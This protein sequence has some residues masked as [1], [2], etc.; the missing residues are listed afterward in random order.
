MAKEE[1]VKE[2]EIAPIE[3]DDRL[4]ECGCCELA[5]FYKKTDLSRGIIKG[6]P[7]RFKL[8][9]HTIGFRNI[10][11]NYGRVDSKGTYILLLK[12][13]HPFPS[14]QKRYVYEHR[15][16]MEDFLRQNYPNHK[17]LI[18]I[19]AKLY[20]RPEYIVHH[21]NGN[22]KDN[23]IENLEFMKA[24]QHNKLHE[25]QRDEFTGRFLKKEIVYG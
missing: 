13:R 20:L 6:K 10:R 25:P 22:I 7:K 14:R 5:G 16:V 1:A 24:S 15:L 2:T 3:A 18:G 23:R 12:P 9:H 11:W 4:C 8:N 17:A 19:N 21:I